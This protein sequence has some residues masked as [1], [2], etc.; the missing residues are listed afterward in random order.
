MNGTDM[1]V[2]MPVTKQ[3]IVLF[4]G[5]GKAI[6]LEDSGHPAETEGLTSIQRAVLV[7]RLREHAN[8]IEAQA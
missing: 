1:T 8:L 3:A 6:F 7:A 4:D 2:V 5:E